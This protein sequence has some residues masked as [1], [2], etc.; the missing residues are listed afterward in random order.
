MGI[1]I[2]AVPQAILLVTVAFSYFPKEKLHLLSKFL[3]SSY[4]PRKTARTLC[5]FSF[6]PA[7]HGIDLCASLNGQ[8]GLAENLHQKDNSERAGNEGNV[9][10]SKA[11]EAKI[12]ARG[13]S[14]QKST[15]VCLGRMS[16]HT[17]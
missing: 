2:P 4:L 3:C 8:F 5:V 13:N 14:R 12:L 1:P 16:S 9:K 6:M 7:L 11:L 15:S 10:K 17:T